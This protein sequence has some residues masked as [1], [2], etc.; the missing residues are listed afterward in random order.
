MLCEKCHQREA[1]VHI[2]QIVGESMNQLNFCEECARNNS[3]A[4]EQLDAKQP[5]PE[6]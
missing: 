6:T 3:I 2:T 4:L 5:F 1:N